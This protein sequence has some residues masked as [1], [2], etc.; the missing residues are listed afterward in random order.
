MKT[1]SLPGR[2]NTFRCSPATS[3]RLHVSRPVLCADDH[4]TSRTS[5]SLRRTP[6]SKLQPTATGLPLRLTGLLPTGGLGRN[7]LRIGQT[8]FVG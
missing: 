7:R 8:M 4:P 3:L 6:K 1:M 2:G 5:G